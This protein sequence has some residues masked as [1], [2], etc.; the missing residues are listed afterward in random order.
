MMKLTFLGTGTSTG[1]PYIGCDCETCLSKDPKDRRLRSSSLLEINGKNILLDCGPDFRQQAL[2]ANLKKI[3]AVL[4]THKHVDHTLG[5]DDLRPYGRVQ[6]YANQETND[7]IHQMFSYCFN[8]DYKGIPQLE[9]HVIKNEP[10]MIDD[11]RV[12]P[13]LIWHYKLPTFGYRINNFAYITDIKTIDKE[14]T[15]KLKGLDVLVMDALR[16]EDHF[17]HMNVEEALALVREVQPKETYFIHMSHT[18]GLHEEAQKKLPEHVHF[19]Y[20]G[21]T[22]EI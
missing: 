22:I 3:D 2:S 20:D 14:E 18:I 10:F 1:V 16:W 21:L 9:T 4:L 8:N 5:L 12:T 17:S 19:A 11:I 7:A 6:I 13:V 15:E